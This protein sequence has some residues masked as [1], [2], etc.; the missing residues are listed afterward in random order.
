M[1][2]KV[3][4][5]TLRWYAPVKRRNEDN[6]IRWAAERVEKGRR[7]RGRPRKRWMDCVKEDGK[8]MDLD[9]VADRVRRNTITKRP[10][11]P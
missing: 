2:D 6:M 5:S 10:D 4:E 9:P 8:V 1:K 3:Q 11:P 7:P